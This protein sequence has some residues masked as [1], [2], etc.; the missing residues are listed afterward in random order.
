M[1]TP[2]APSAG[3]LLFNSE[4]E[5]DLSFSVSASPADESRWRFPA[6]SFV[7]RGASPVFQALVDSHKHIIELMAARRERPEIYVQ[8][9]PE[10]F[11]IILR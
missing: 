11:H 8:C 10:I 9:P 7:L 4:N 3:P 6:H 5:S 2:S 1:V